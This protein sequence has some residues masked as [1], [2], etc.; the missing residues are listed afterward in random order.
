M[1]RQR[2]AS[3]LFVIACLCAQAPG[4][5]LPLFVPK[6]SPPEAHH[7]EPDHSRVVTI[8][9]TSAMDQLVAQN[10]FVA[11]FFYAPWCGHSIMITPSWTE[12]SIR[13]IGTDV[14]LAKVDLTRPSTAALRTRYGIRG[15]PA[16]KIFKA[17]SELPYEYRG[18]R[19]TDGIVQYLTVERNR[20]TDCK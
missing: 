12:A 20:C 1:T 14:M 3:S 15:F 11:V 13:F 16:L 7:A 4:K 19:D 2:S 5:K 8:M 6:Q 17:H 10:S 9:N 18:P